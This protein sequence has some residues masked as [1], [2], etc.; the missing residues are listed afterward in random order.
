[1]AHVD[2]V[3]SKGAAVTIVGTG[4]NRPR[5]NLYTATGNLGPLSPLAGGTATTI[6]VTVPAS[7]PTGPATFQAVNAPYSGNVISNAVSA[8]VGAAPAITSVSVVGQTITVTGAGFSVLSVINL[9]NKQGTTVVNLG[10]FGPGG[11]AIPLALIN[12]TQFTFVRPA[13]AVA[14]P[15]FVEVLNPPYIPFSSSGSDPDGAFA[16]P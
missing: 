5:L 13:G 15:A 9:F 10:G 8:V 11:P 12:D 14:G 7:A 3:L 1:V 4:F 2:T 6:R 16:F